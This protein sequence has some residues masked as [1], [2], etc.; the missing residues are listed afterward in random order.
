MPGDM[1]LA[2]LQA[3]TESC[4]KIG[5]EATVTEVSAERKLTI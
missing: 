4:E 3:V 5:R 1:N 2:E